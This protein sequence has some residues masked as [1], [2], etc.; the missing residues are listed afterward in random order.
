MLGSLK[1]KSGS[2]II[3][4][5]AEGVDLKG[6]SFGLSFADLVHSKI[7]FAVKPGGLTSIKHLDLFLVAE[8]Y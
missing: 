1:A 3:G 4:R 7:G 6:C 5:E 8:C 2:L